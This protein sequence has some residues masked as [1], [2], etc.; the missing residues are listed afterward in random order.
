[1]SIL[2]PLQS[3][4]DTIN[5]RVCPLYSYD[6]RERVYMLGSAVPFKS[7]G[8]SFLITVAHIILANEGNVPLFTWGTK[9]PLLLRRPRLAWEYD[10]RRTPDLDIAL[11]AL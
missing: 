7:G 8:I 1:M 9:G 5:R 2:A 3:I 6:E 11:I 10:P 4:G